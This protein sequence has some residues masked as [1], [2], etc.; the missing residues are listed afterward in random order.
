[1]DT[2]KNVSNEMA[3]L[4]ETVGAGVV[5]VEA[6][7]RMSATGVV[8]TEDGVIATS[9]HVVTRDENI[10]V[11]LPNGETVEAVLVGRDPSTDL[12]ILKADVS[13]LTVPTWV[14]SNEAAVGHLVLALGRPGNTVQATLGVVSALGDSFQAP[15]GGKIDRYFQT[16]VVMYPGFSG[17]PLAAADGAVLGVNT[18]ALMR[19]TSLTIPTETVKRVA[20]ALLEHG[21]IKRGYLGVTAQTVRLPESTAAEAG[22]ETG[23]LV[24]S[25]EP[26]SPAAQG[27]I[28]LGDVIVKLGDTGTRSMDELLSLLM[29]DV[30]GKEVSVTVVR[31]GEMAT[32]PVTIGERK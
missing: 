1:M 26:E 12:A 31:G 27:G 5:R 4:V 24:A 16:D 17:G 15:G 20:D 23:L 21:H 18:S 10:R 7:K 6:R 25:V 8:M 2:L 19:G 13:G 11:G 30:V 32:I 22:Q 28:L 14:T 9:H 3:Q 29:G